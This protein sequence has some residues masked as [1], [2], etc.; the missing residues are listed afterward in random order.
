MAKVANPRKDFQFTVEIDGLNAFEC[1]KFTPADVEVDVVAHADTNHDVKTGGRLKVGEIVMEKLKPLPTSDKWAWDWL[2][3]VQNPI[4][5]GG[6]L[7]LNYKKPVVVRELDTTG[8][9]V[10][11]TWVYSGCFVSKI[12]NK[13]LD[14]M[15]SDNQI[16]TVTIQADVPERK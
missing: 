11:N 6:E 7:P 8:I 10:V 5:G 3:S 4:T 13:P 1:Q 14:R 2:M 16:E 12:S 9:I 15:S